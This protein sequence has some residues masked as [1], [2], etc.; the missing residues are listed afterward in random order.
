[1]QVRFETLAACM[2]GALGAILQKKSDIIQAVDC[3]TSV[4]NWL[5]ALGGERATD[6]AAAAGSGD[7][8]EGA[9]GGGSGGGGLSARHR[10][11]AEGARVPA[12]RAA[13]ER[14][15]GED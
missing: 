12:A 11:A 6:D 10:R 14:A 2:K 3:V 4:E 9:G 1:M 5:N 15:G 7:G 8:A 13:R